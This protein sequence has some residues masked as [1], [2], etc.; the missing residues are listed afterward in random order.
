MKLSIC[1]PT[2]N[3]KDKVKEQVK[4]IVDTGILSRSAEV[5]LVVSDNCSEDKTYEGLYPMYGEVPGIRLFC[6]DKNLGL[7]G[8]LY[9]LFEEAKGEYIWFLSDDD[10]IVPDSISSILNVISH[11]NLPFYLLNFKIEGNNY[12]YWC[13]NDDYLSL[14]TDNTWGGF[15]LLSIQILKKSKFDN[16]YTNTIGSYNLCQPVAVSLYGLYYLKGMM[17]FD[18]IAITHHAG[19]Y[20]WQD[21]YLQVGSV[22]LYDSVRLLRCCG[23]EETYKII[24]ASLKRLNHFCELSFIYIM[25]TRDF[26]YVHKLYSDK[27]LFTVVVKTPIRVFVSKIKNI[28]KKRCYYVV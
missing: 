1:I 16:F 4:R 13:K 17:C 23:N 21:R 22:Y 14:F 6:Q 10:P 27:L 28:F 5:E 24:I 18:I 2:Y 25:K 12:P 11:S 15:G 9:F 19:D 26:K 7:V 3:R 8:N 20:S